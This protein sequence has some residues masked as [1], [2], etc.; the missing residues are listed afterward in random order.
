MHCEGLQTADE[1]K[2][3]SLCLVSNYLYSAVAVLSVLCYGDTQENT[4]EHSMSQDIVR[5][6][7]LITITSMHH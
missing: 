3:W 7:I 2:R 6:N 1:N 5:L 4:P